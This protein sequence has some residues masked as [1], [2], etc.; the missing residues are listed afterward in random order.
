M[1]FSTPKENR[2]VL[3]GGSLPKLHT[4][5]S[6]PPWLPSLVHS[7][8]RSRL[9]SW[10]GVWLQGKEP[11]IVPAVV[12]C[13][14]LLYTES[15]NKWALPYPGVAWWSS[16]DYYQISNY[17]PGVRMGPSHNLQCEFNFLGR[18][19]TAVF[20]SSQGISRSR[21]MSRGTNFKS[22]SL[23]DTYFRVQSSQHTAV[24]TGTVRY[25]VKKEQI[26]SLWKVTLSF[27]SSPLSYVTNKKL[28]LVKHWLCWGTNLQTYLSMT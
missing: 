20:V 2:E 9:C 19:E 12:L 28:S 26:G 5:N 3:I 27:L 13:Y 4:C 10:C 6:Q 16:A 25:Y 14:H 17:E 24:I 18:L 15:M 7:H 23:C 21:V 8:V 22:L 11:L 1:V